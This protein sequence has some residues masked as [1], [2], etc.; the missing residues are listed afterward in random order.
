M[1]MLSLRENS[2]MSIQ[3]VV[4]DMDDTLFAEKDYVLSGL[5]AVHNWIGK[6]YYISNFLN[7]A[8]YV[9]QQGEKKFIFNRTLDKLHIK[10]EPR[11]I[12]QMV[13]VYRNHKPNIYLLEDA[14]WVLNNIRDKIKIG[15]ISDGFLVAQENKVKA[16]KL[17]DRIHSIILTDQLGRE[18]WKP[19]PIPFE[20]SSKELGF[21]HD[22]CVYVGDNVNKDFVTAKK[23]GWKTVHINRKEGVYSNNNYKANDSY[24]A[25]YM[26]DDLRELP[27]IPVLSHVFKVKK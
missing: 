27:D 20:I 26:V 18:F 6:K 16:L 24:Q 15:L 22:Q 13:G 4:F 23:L 9:M 5:Q 11:I 12:D 2:S 25:H 3:A 10:Y 1:M 14:E 21:P 7:T 17:R 8:L 19:S